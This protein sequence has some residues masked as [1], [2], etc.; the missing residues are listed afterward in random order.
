[1]RLEE[2]IKQIKFHSQNHKAIVNVIYTCNWLLY[3]F[4]KVLKPF[5]L[6]PQQY[7]VLR[8]LRGH[9]P[10]PIGVNEITERMLDKMSNVSRLVEKLRKKGLAERKINK[11]DRRG[12]EIFITEKGLV[13]LA[14]LDKPEYGL[15]QIESL[16]ETEAIEMNLLIDKIRG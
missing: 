11:T 16:N 2:E 3:K 15:E 6:S 7:N 9:N 13:L 12:V 1:M 4:C 8:I 5:G 14:E 10:E